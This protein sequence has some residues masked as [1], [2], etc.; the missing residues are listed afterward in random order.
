MSLSMVLYIAASKKKI[1][2][3]TALIIWQISVIDICFNS[4]I[5]VTFTQ[6]HLHDLC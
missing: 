6:A 4:V 3:I 1:D 5:I 2:L